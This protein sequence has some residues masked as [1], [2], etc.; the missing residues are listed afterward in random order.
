MLID[1]NSVQI[2]ELNEERVTLEK[3]LLHQR[4]NEDLQKLIQVIKEFTQKPVL[5]EKNGTQTYR[6]NRNKRRWESENLSQILGSL[7]LFFLP[8]DSNK[9]WFYSVAFIQH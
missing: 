5:D 2:T 4:K 7:Y 6:T 1:D 8:N 3:R 9:F